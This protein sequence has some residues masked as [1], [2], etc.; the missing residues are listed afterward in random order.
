MNATILFHLKLF[1]GILTAISTILI[2]FSKNKEAF[3][4]F[5]KIAGIIFRVLQS[6]PILA[7]DLFFR[8]NLFNMQINRVRFDNPKK[9]ELFQILLQEIVRS[10][11]NYTRTV[12]KENYSSL[13][14]MR[15]PDLAGFLFNILQTSQM[16]YETEILKK[17]QLIYGKPLGQQI[18]N[19]VY[20]A[21]AEYRRRN[22]DFLND[23]IE[24]FS[25][26]SSKDNEDIIRTFLILIQIT[27]DI[28]VSNCEESFRNQN[29]TLEKLINQNA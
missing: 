1:G 12:F 25:S 15:K 28:A 17:Y 24:T 2:W 29:G 7:Q 8:E 10:S 23:S 9:T 13:K 27:L 4:I 22:F 11:I 20:P 6:K 16:M 14:T 19:Q 26:S 21:Y 18:Y 5:R 3:S